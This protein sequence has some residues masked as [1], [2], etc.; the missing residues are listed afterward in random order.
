MTSAEL[1]IT[2]YFDRMSARPGEKLT[3]HVSVAKGG[4][5]R[6]R[7]KRAISVD[8]NPKGPGRRFE[9][10]SRLFDESFDGRRQAIQIGSYAK[11]DPAPERDAGIARTWTA[12]VW[13]T[14]PE[15]DQVVLSDEDADGRAVLAIGREGAELAVAGTRLATGTELKPRRWYRLWASASPDGRLRVGQ[16]A[17]DGKDDAAAEARAPARLPTDG[18]IMVGAEDATAPRRHFS[19]KIEAPAIL[20]TEIA[21]WADPRVLPLDD[22]IAVWDFVRGIGTDMIRDTGPRA[23]HGVTVNMPMRGMVGAFWTGEE[24]SWRHAPEDYAAIHF[25]PGDLED[26]RWQP[27]FTFTVPQDLK[28][29]SYLLHLSCEGGEDWLPFFVRPREGGKR[30]RIV[31]LASTFTYQ[32]YANFARLVDEADYRARVAAFQAYPYLPGDYPIYGRSTYNTHED[33]AGVSISSRRR[34]ILT[35]RPGYIAANDPIGSGVRHY[36][37]DHHLLAWLEEKEIDFDIVTDEDLDDEGVAVLAP[38]RAVLTGSHPEYH[39]GRMLDAL[40]AYR[41]QGGRIAYLGGNGFYWK[42]ARDPARP[43]LIEV[44]RAEGGVRLW[45]CEPGE[46][47]HML[48]GQLG[49]LWRRNRRPPQLLV[50]IGFAVQGAY[51]ATYYRRMPGSYDPRTSWIFAGINEEIIGDYGLCGGCAA[52]FELDR[53]D[54]TLG[55]PENAVILARSENHP[56]S[57]GLVPEDLLAPGRTIMHGPPDDLARAD[58]IYFDRPE[59]GAV[60]SVGS[61][62]FLGALWRNGFEGPVS[63]LLYNVVKRFES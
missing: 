20:S 39:T 38:Y 5:F 55:T 41:D 52:G 7:L 21:S 16:V 63:Q 37:A 35:M 50:G 44:R 9:D 59:G 47:H 22:R 61:I 33:G 23:C 12:L 43:H 46:Y 3:V 14:L 10:L 6:A 30:A 28:S 8:A 18:V 57:F 60:F 49:G 29:G 40:T 51:E 19:G 56:A 25:H 2:G 36:I 17:L 4:T 27:D 34:P 48:D 54:A 1:P 42:I 31:F 53:T 11:V 24:T 26:C 45:Q 58:M 62:T 15:R 32:A 13:T